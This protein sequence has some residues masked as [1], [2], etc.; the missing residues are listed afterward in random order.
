MAMSNPVDGF[1]SEGEPRMIANPPQIF[2]TL[3][4]WQTVPKLSD[5]ETWLLSSA[6]RRK[7]KLHSVSFSN[8]WIS[9]PA[10]CRK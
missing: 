3:S 2:L 7:T 6:A 4:S 9:A 5:W 10:L 1:S 8:S